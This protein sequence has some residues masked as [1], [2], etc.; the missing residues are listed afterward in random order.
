[1]EQSLGRRHRGEDADFGAAARLPHN[2]DVPWIAAKVGDVVAN[3]LESSHNIQHA[4]VPGRGEVFSAHA[5]KIA[6]PQR[7]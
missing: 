5:G 6:E 1:M 2:G 4:H 3:P 7:T